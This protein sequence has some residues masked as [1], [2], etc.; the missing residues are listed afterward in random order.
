[1]YPF[2]SLYIYLFPITP[3]SLLHSGPY[4]I[5]WA[6]VVLYDHPANAS[7]PPSN[8]T[9]SLIMNPTGVDSSAVAILNFDTLRAQAIASCNLNAQD[10]PAAV[11]IRGTKG[12]L[13]VHGPSYMPTGLTLIT[14]QGQ[15]TTRSAE[16]L[17]GGPFEG[18]GWHYQVYQLNFSLTFLFVY[19][20]AN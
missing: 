10:L 9:G 16:A 15:E 14:A 12:T 2:S 5:L 19:E 17:Q 13:V 18:T 6:I 3:P 11:T 7:R 4:A 20:L 1:V 8:V